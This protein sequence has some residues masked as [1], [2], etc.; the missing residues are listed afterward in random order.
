MITGRLQ[1]E[2]REAW[3]SLAM[4]IGLSPVRALDTDGGFPGALVA[5]HG[6]VEQKSDRAECAPDD[7]HRAG[8]GH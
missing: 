4:V 7:P 6:G 2:G 3:Q 5:H 1:K 8:K